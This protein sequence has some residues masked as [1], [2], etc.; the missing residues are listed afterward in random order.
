MTDVFDWFWE[1]PGLQVSDNF[2]AYLRAVIAANGGVMWPFQEKSG[3]YPQAYNTALAVGRQLCIDGDM[4]T[5]GVAAWTAAASATLTK[6]AGTPHGGAQCL[7]IA[8]NGTASPGA[9][10]T[11]LAT[12]R[13]YRVTGW[14]RSDGVSIP[15]VLGGGTVIFTG[16]TSTDWQAIDVS[17]TADGTTFKLYA[18]LTVAGYSE[19]DDVTLVQTNILAGTSYPGAELLVDGNMETAGVAAWAAM[20][21]ATLTKQTGTPHGGTQVLRVARNAVNNPG[22]MQT[23]LTAGKRYRFI[24]WVRSDGNAL[25]RI[26]ANGSTVWQGTTATSWQSFDFELVVTTTTIELRAATS[27]GTEY[28]EFDDV[29]VTAVNILN[30]TNTGATVAQLVNSRL[31]FG[32]LLDGANDFINVYSGTF[33][34][35]FNPLAGTLIAFVQAANAGVWTDSIARYIWMLQV[36]AT[37]KICV[38]KN[39]AN[40]SLYYAY[41][42]GGTS[43]TANPACTL[44]TVFM[45]ALTW[46]KVADEVKFYI[47]GVQSGATLTGLGVWEGNLV[48]TVTVIG[49]SSITPAAV[50]SGLASW[51]TLLRA[52]LTPTEILQI[53]RDAG[54][55]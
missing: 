43:K 36:N 27:T 42:A 33:N 45:V 49:A 37:N 54:V 4:E 11:I 50:W 32:Y 15:R 8:Y 19:W 14:V 1:L 20:Q 51:P 6:E 10:Q 53:A 9:S 25:P 22:A 31:G 5:A 2:S 17:F 23:V 40:N 13:T 44:T 38:G 34:S 41:I 21:S 3:S 35:F 39:A 28:A 18:V 48:S 46:D 7:R 55:A 16:T 47:N 24:G 26:V 12:G 30:G 29:S 52:A